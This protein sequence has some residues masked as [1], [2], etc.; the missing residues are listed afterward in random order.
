MR[1]HRVHL[2]SFGYEIPEQVISSEE[3]EE[4][5]APYYKKNRIPEGR[6]EQLTGIRERRVWE[7]SVAPSEKSIL[8]ARKALEKSAL[9]PSDIGGII[10]CSVCRDATDYASASVVHKA[11]GLPT[12]AFCFD[13]T[14][15]CI[16]FINGITTL[17]NMIELQQIQAGIVVATESVNEILEYAIED[18]LECESKQAAMERFTCLTGGSGSVAFVLTSQN[19]SK[20]TH[21]LLG[22]TVRVHSEHVDLCRWQPDIGFPSTRRHQ[23]LTNGQ[24]ILENGCKLAQE[25]WAEL[26]NELHWTNESVDRVFSH[27]IGLPHQRYLYKQLGIDWSKDFSTIDFL[28]NIGSVSLP[29]T[30]S[31][32]AEKGHLRPGDKIAMFG[33]GSGL[34]CCMMGLQW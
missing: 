9:K 29:I 20:T 22:Y 6:L 21:R 24:A 7:A 4:R 26:K 2:E 10:H 15:A 23:L 19:I 12:N 11:L 31:M 3:I 1:Y 32:G 14:N 28:G 5:L 17:A 25:T 27:Q 18:I 13:I 34:N 30:M 8:A 33:I 16:G